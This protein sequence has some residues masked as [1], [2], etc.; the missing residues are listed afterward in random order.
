MKLLNNKITK[1]RDNVTSIV[2]D[3]KSTLN[4]QLKTNKQSKTNEQSTS[5]KSSKNHLSRASQ[6]KFISE[7][8]SQIVFISTKSTIVSKNE[9]FSQIIFV[10]NEN[11]NKRAQ[12]REI[13]NRRTKID[14]QLIDDLIYY[15]QKFH[16]KNVKQSKFC[17]SKSCQRNVFQITHD[18]NF[19]IDYYRAYRKLM[20]TIYMSIILRKLRLYLRH[21]SLCQFNQTKRYNF[22]DELT[23]IFTS[24]LSFRTIIMNFI[25]VLSKKK[26][27][28]LI[29]IDKV[30][31]QLQII[32][33]EII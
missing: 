24:S 32:V 4:K 13:N 14:F 30:S 10:N 11:S 21:C 17:V 9:N 6:L 33:D 25:F 26:I 28:I 22:Y 31:R 1:K 2:D 12:T 3:D 19:H 5:N 16:E 8:F 18:N 7:N 27:C 15:I 23:F 20:K 29:L